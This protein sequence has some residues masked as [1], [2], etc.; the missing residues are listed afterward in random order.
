MLSEAERRFRRDKIWLALLSGG[1]F[2]T[3]FFLE[4]CH[5]SLSLLLYLFGIRTLPYW[6]S[7]STLPQSLDIFYAFNGSR[8][9][10]VLSSKISTFLVYAFIKRTFYQNVLKLSQASYYIHRKI[11]TIFDRLKF[12]RETE[13]W[14][15]KHLLFPQIL[16]K[17]TGLL[18]LNLPKL[19]CQS[20]D[21]F[22][23]ACWSV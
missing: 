14:C 16:P 22:H 11:R 8:G 13:Y 7:W 4:G 9:P 18:L 5:R 20:A 6:Q 15:I 2:K 10:L 3:L 12:P 23:N 21:T 1:N 19:Y 17:I